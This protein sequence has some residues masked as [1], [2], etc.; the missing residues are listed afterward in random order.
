MNWAFFQATSCETV[1]YGLQNFVCLSIYGGMSVALSSGSMR[2]HYLISCMEGNRKNAEI[3]LMETIG[4]EI[5]NILS[6][7]GIRNKCSA[8]IGARHAKSIQIYHKL[9]EYAQS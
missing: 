2:W 3:V 6:F 5:L 1:F 8:N 7:H 9:H 4:G